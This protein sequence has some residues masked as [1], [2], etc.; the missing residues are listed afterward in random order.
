MHPT[1]SKD[2]VPAP[3]ASS[4]QQPPIVK[5]PGMWRTFTRGSAGMWRE[6]ETG[7]PTLPSFPEEMSNPLLGSYT[8]P[9]EEV[10]LSGDQPRTLHNRHPPHT[11]V[12]AVFGDQHKHLTSTLPCVNTGFIWVVERGLDQRL[13]W[14]RAKNET[15]TVSEPL[16]SSHQPSSEEWP[17]G[18]AVKPRLRSQA[19]CCHPHCLP[20]T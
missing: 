9:S 3:N 4:L 14:L 17:G 16:V 19:A 20:A 1:P 5:F 11:L 7:R 2:A 18:S 13:H 15:D 8:S 12:M 10:A 6:E